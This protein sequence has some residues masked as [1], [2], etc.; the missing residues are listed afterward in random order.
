QLLPAPDHQ[1]T[2]SFR[3]RNDRDN[4]VIDMTA[5]GTAITNLRIADET[6][7]FDARD[8]RIADDIQ[9]APAPLLQV[10]GLPQ[11]IYA[12]SIDGLPAAEAT[13]AEWA[14]GVS[15]TGEAVHAPAQQLRETILEKCERYFFRWRAH[16]GEYIYGRRARTGNGNAGNPQFQDEHAEMDRIIAAL[17]QT[18]ADLAQPRPRTYELIRVDKE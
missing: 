5:R 1:W 18:I 2:V 15:L 13:A 16:N 9:P 7:R 4:P 6:I 3:A 11:G 12:L 14:A 17:D 8:E 10:E